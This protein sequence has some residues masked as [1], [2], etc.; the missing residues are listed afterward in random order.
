ML[1]RITFYDVNDSLEVESMNLH[2]IIKLKESKTARGPMKVLVLST[3]K[4]T[5]KHEL[6][7]NKSWMQNSYSICN[8][9]LNSCE[10]FVDP[11]SKL[12]K[13]LHQFQVEFH[14]KLYRVDFVLRLFTLSN[15]RVV[16]K[17]QCNVIFLHIP[18]IYT[19][20]F[21]DKEEKMYLFHSLL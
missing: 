6:Q 3:F 1:V 10:D 19:T 11:I 16:W 7:N 13:F 15:D 2:N 14:L 8:Q 18:R 21:L 17:V 5:Y 20:I 4:S 9:K 12:T